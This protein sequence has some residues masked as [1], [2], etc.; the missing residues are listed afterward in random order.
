MSEPPPPEPRPPV[1]PVD[2][3]VVVEEREEIVP[4]R[5]PPLLWPWLL[6]FLLLVLG[7]LGAYWYFSQEDTSTVPAV[8][9]Q[10]QDAAEADVR[11][12]G[13]EPQSEQAE[14]A[15]PKGLVIAQ[16]PEGGSELEDG[17][18]VLLTI[19]AGPPRETVPDVVGQTQEAAVADLTAA[20][21]KADV[22]QAFSDKQAGVV[23]AQE[24]KAG[25]NLKE[26]SS[27]ALTVSKG[28]KPVEVP[29]VVGTTSSEATATLREAGL[30]VNLVPVPSDQPGG[31]VLAQ[32]PKA[33]ATAKS[34]TKV[35]LN[36][37]QSPG[38][39]TPAT[40]QATT[41][42]ATTTAPTPTQPPA[43]A[44]VPDVV[45]KELADAARA[46]GD[47]GLKVAVKLVPSNEARG[48]VI[49]Q[50]QPAG[51]ERKRGDTVQVNV[52]LGANP[53]A[54]ATVPNTAGKPEQEARDQLE[55]AGFEVLAIPV[56]TADGS[57]EGRVLS[58]TPAGNAQIPGGSLVI[59]YVGTATS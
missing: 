20:K 12:A 33:G 22:T 19:S 15:K 58:Q 34:G 29:D 36:V 49:A 9:G 32:S 3:T 38:A 41:T 26:G 28:Q 54:N 11:A 39:T 1:D 44:T 45:G 4:P 25:A 10:R 46:F 37:A 17:K 31:T 52:A 40:T 6:A 55:A 42:Q 47:E 56:E 35:R 59:L 7:G 27:V 8:V 21:F 30:G 13:F 16:R 14:S 53:P 50:A 18:A 2:E 23:I 51:T 5:R 24:P 43:S 48:T 57:R